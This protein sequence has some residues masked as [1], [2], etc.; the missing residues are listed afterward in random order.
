M[1]GRDETCGPSVRVVLRRARHA[2][3]PR[4]VDLMSGSQAA[5]RGFSPELGERSFD[6]R[7]SRRCFVRDLRQPRLR[8][9]VGCANARVVAM[10]GADFRRVNYRHAVTRRYVY[11]HSLYVV[12]EWRGR[13]IARRLVRRALR[14]GVRCG[15]RQARIEMAASN[16]AAGRLY[17]SFGFVTRERMLTMPLK[18]AR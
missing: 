4:L 18:D 1:S 9:W 6:V 11:V 16:A 13:G 14:W 7:H 3:L 10:I 5:E 8:W 17:G 15:A 2:D 12:P